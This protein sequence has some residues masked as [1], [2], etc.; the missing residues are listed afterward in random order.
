MIEESSRQ[1]SPDP[2]AVARLVTVAVIFVTALCTLL[3]ATHVEGLNGPWYWKWPWQD[4]GSAAARALMFLAFLPFLYAQLLLAHHR[5]R[6]RWAL[7]LMMLSLFC[8]QL[9]ATELTSTE[10]AVARIVRIVKDPMLTSYHFNAQKVAGLRHWLATYP[11][12][13][14]QYHMHSRNKPPGTMLYF[15][16]LKRLLPDPRAS[17]LAGGLLMGLLATLCL[18]ALYWL[19]QTLTGNRAA[20]LHAASFFAL[21]P[22]LVLFFPQFDQCFPVISCLLVGA[23][24]LAL[25]T[26]RARHA[27]GCGLILSAILF[28]SWNFLVLGSFLVMLALI[29]IFRT[30]RTGLLPVARQSLLALGVVAIVYLLL[31][32]MLGYDPVQTFRTSLD[33]ERAMAATYGRSYPATILFDLTDFVFGSGW[34]GGLLALMYF[35][36][37]AGRRERDRELALAAAALLQLLVVAVTGLLRCET[38]RVWLFLYPLLL[39]PVGLRLAALPSAVRLTVY[40]CLWLLTVVIGCNMSLF[41]F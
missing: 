12:H 40:C 10:H 31:W 27:L 34:L 38:I 6:H 39:L 28:I 29:H 5:L 8:L 1:P 4:T 22:G 35:I 15:V 16:L 41:N 25:T 33:L 32:Q 20:A 17:A 2:P 23:W 3:V 21:T 18:P 37:K 11:S 36:R 24:W 19:I 7:L 30:G 9:V 14:A 13:L 26:G